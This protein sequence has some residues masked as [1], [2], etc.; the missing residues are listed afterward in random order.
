VKNGDADKPIWA[1]EMGWNVQPQSVTA[2]PVFGRVSE[3]LQAKYTVRAFQRAAEEWPWMGV[4]SIWF[5][6]RAD[7]NEVN[8][9]FYYFRM[10]DPDFRPL[11]VYSA[12]KEMAT[13]PPLLRKG[14]SAVDNPAISYKGDWKPSQGAV[15][16]PGQR[17]MASAEGSTVSFSFKGNDLTLLAPRGSDLGSAHVIIDGKA[18]MANRL[19]RD[20][21]GMAVLSLSSGSPVLEDRIPLATGLMNDVHRVEIRTMG[22]FAL[23]GFIVETHEVDLTWW[24]FGF[25]AMVGVPLGV[26]VVLF[27]ALRRK[28][29][30]LL[31]RQA[32]EQVL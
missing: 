13:K 12:I 27:V 17:L 32:K 29:R 18:V 30:G 21:S 25:A 16:S 1:S 5:L 8:E 10:V 3:D 22:P 20:T 2:L 28:R 4:M 7:H 6:K 14:Y 24:V 31:P 9:P 15:A 19:L 11:P 23:D 26:G